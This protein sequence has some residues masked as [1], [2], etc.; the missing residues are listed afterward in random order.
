M[1]VQRYYV[2]RYKNLVLL[3]DTDGSDSQFFPFFGLKKV[4]ISFAIK[5]GIVRVAPLGWALL[6]CALI[7]WAA[8]GQAPLGWV[9]LVNTGYHR[10]IQVNTG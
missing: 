7:R 5:T 1:K 10:L 9:P 3:T 6:G 8:L 2:H 4:R